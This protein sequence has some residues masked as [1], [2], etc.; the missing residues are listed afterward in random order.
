[1]DLGRE[2]GAEGAVPQMYPY[3]GAPATAE[4]HGSRHMDLGRGPGAEGAV[5]HMNL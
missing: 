5:P 3:S 2:A 1:M 4:A